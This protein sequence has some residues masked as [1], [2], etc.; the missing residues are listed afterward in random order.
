MAHEVV[1]NQL[2]VRFAD[3]DAVTE[4]VVAQLQTEN[5]CFAES[6]RWRGRSVMRVSIIAGDLDDHDIKRLADAII[7]AWR[8]TQLEMRAGCAAS[9]AVQS[10]ERTYDHEV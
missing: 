3:D 9:A 1:L 6:A 5:V 8:R 10:S 4:A 7:G 2:I